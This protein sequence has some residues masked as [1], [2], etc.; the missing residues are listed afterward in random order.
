MHIDLNC[1][2]GEGCPFDAELMPLITSANVSC[3]RHAGDNAS[4]ATALRLAR[5]HGVQVGAHPGYPDPLNFGRVELAWSGDE[6]VRECAEQIAAMKA[7]AD[8]Q[9]MWLRY[10]KPHGALY[11]QACRDAGYAEPIVQAARQFQLAVMGLPDSQLAQAA[12]RANIRFIAE[13]FAD[14]RYLPD[15]SLVPRSRPDAFVEN[16]LEA[17]QQA[18]WLVR[19]RGVETICVHGDNPQ[20]VAFVKQLRKSLQ[21]AGFT[22]RAFAV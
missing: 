11:N 12:A 19:E 3:G 17:A 15:G 18:A 5:E 7:L 2:L 1:D 9:G 10:L 13:G 20:A 4:I 6:I 22:I 8:V 14:R 16:P 21:A